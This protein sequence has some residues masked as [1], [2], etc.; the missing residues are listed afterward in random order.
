VVPNTVPWQGWGERWGVCRPVRKRAG[1][2]TKPS[3]TRP[4]ERDDKDQLPTSIFHSNSRSLPTTT[5]SEIQ[6]T[7]VIG[8][9]LSPFFRPFLALFSPFSRPFLDPF[10][11]SHSHSTPYFAYYS[12]FAL[13]FGIPCQQTVTSIPLANPFPT[14]PIIPPGKF[15]FFSLMRV[16][17]Q[18]QQGCQIPTHRDSGCAPN[19]RSTYLYLVTWISAASR[20]HCL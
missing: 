5:S 20:E 3:P 13:F 9:P 17:L 11:P 16:C 7:F 4:N 19:S 2:S 6:L 15:F 10:S 1:Y 8:R 14:A 12:Y 18:T